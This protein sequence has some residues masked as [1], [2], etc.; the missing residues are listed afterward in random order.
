[1]KLFKGYLLEAKIAAN[2]IEIVFQPVKIIIFYQAKEVE[3]KFAYYFLQIV[4]KF[5]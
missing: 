3:A 1:M 4:V 5:T 2:V